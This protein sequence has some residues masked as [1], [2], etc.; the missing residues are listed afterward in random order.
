MPDFWTRLKYAF[1]SFFSLL[2]RGELPE[3]VAREFLTSQQAPTGLLTAK[4]APAPERKESVDGAVQT[5]AL[6]QRDGRLIDFLSE[7]VAPYPDAQLGAAVRSVHESC[8]QVV[9]RYFKLE[10]ILDS[11][12]DK[13]VTVQAGFDAA[14]IKLI[15]NVTGQPPIRG[16]LRHRGWRVKEASLPSLP[17]GAGRMVVAP[18][19]VE[20]P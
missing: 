10:P 16:L 2:S 1:D 13:L 3:E 17:Q 4:V 20:V 6:L 12:E 7:D 11:E 19:E 18:A 5:L 14:A 9:D 15:G 8:K